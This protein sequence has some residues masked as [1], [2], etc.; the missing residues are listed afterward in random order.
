MPGQA[1]CMELI[2]CSRGT[3]GAWP[4]ILYGTGKINILSARD[5]S[6]IIGLSK[7]L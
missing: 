3:L 5:Y 7:F 2:K 6:K 4:G 1:Y